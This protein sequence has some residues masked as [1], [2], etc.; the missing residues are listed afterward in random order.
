MSDVINQLFSHLPLEKIT[1]FSCGHIT[2]EEN[3]QTLVVNKGPDGGDLEFKAD[4]Q[5]N[6]A[7]VRLYFI[8]YS[9]YILNIYNID[10]SAWPGVT[11]F[12]EYSA[13]RDDRVLPFL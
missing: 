13:G 7:T 6:P 5:N 4:K 1:S 2:P 8:L 3:L 10:C 11:E 12:Y 9:E